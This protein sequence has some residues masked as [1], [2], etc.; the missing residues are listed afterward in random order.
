MKKYVCEGAN[1]IQVFKNLKGVSSFIG[2]SEEKTRYKFRASKDKTVIH[3]DKNS[4]VFYK[5]KAIDDKESSVRTIINKHLVSLKNYKHDGKISFNLFLLEWQER[6]KEYPKNY[7][8]QTFYEHLLKEKAKGNTNYF[9]CCNEWKNN[10]SVW[11]CDTETTFTSEIPH[12][13]LFKNPAKGFGLS[14]KETIDNLHIRAETDKKK[15]EGLNEE[16]IKQIT[17]KGV[18]EWFKE[19]PDKKPYM[20]AWIGLNFIT[21]EKK[22]LTYHQAVSYLDN[23]T[24]NTK[25]YYHNLSYD[26]L[27]VAN[28]LIDELDY[29]II[30]KETCDLNKLD[31]TFIPKKLIYIFAQ[32]N[33]IFSMNI[34]NSYGTLIEVECTY[35]KTL[36]S[37]ATLGTILGKPKED[38][39]YLTPRSK[40]H[41]FSP[42]EIK[43]ISTDVE[44]VVEYFDRVASEYEKVFGSKLKWKLTLGMTAMSNL[45]TFF[46][47][48][49]DNNFDK[50]FYYKTEIQDSKT[51]LKSILSPNE[52]I[53]LRKGIRIDKDTYTGLGYNGG[54]SMY[55]IKHVGITLDKVSS[56]DIKSSYPDKEQHWKLPFGAPLYDCKC[57]NTILNNNSQHFKVYEL[58]ILRNL[59]I[60]EGKENMLPIRTT[61]KEINGKEL[62]AVDYYPF[63]RKGVYVVSQ[64]MLQIFYTLFEPQEKDIA[65]EKTMCF[66]HK[67]IKGLVNYVSKWKELKEKPNLKKENSAFYDL[68]KLFLNAPTGKFGQKE[69]LEETVFSIDD[70]GIV[71]K[72]KPKQVKIFEDLKKYSYI[73]IIMAITDMGRLQ[74]LSLIEEI[75]WDYWVTSDTDS[76]KFLLPEQF[77]PAYKPTYLNLISGKRETI[78]NEKGQNEFGKW[79]L[80]WTSRRFKCSGK[81]KYIYEVWDN[82]LEK[83]VTKVVCAGATDDIKE[84][85]DFTTF[86]C[87]FQPEQDEGTKQVKINGLPVI[88]PTSFNI[89]DVFKSKKLS[90]EFSKSLVHDYYYQHTLRIDEEHQKNKERMKVIKSYNKN[91]WEINDWEKIYS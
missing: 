29:K 85:M 86:F 62:S 72:E 16:Q 81:K 66:E 83:L 67:K 52:S 45:K 7:F 68:T 43:Y 23:L 10:N 59:K 48:D 50:S 22:L 56:L 61:V 24:L 31:K 33:K 12:H 53:Y 82:K 57:D 39:N 9:K 91:S 64:Y 19:N 84:K 77:K 46:D 80:E 25:H 5:I 49:Q 18:V 2:L 14:P 40:N 35:L 26:A 60:I 69:V 3:W 42:K 88:L 58:K 54:W 15:L 70:L 75:G 37:V 65:I 27:Y 1:Q 73:P 47:K 32:D 34:W 17:K 30:D 8:Y 90:I 51:L 55:N 36:S 21:K 6:V 44:I 74:L 28:A 4:D 71:N 78:Y 13:Y 38:L 76:G 89:K 41:K 11:M 87:G 20:W 63:I 79:E